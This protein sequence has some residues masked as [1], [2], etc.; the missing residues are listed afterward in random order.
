[1]ALMSAN[2]NDDSDDAALQSKHSRQ[3]FWFFPPQ[4]LAM[5]LQ[6]GE[7]TIILVHERRSNYNFEDSDA[8]SL[9]RSLTS[10]SRFFVSA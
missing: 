8:T 5:T 3:S 6:I 9:A 7:A 1:M 4:R 10:S 2:D